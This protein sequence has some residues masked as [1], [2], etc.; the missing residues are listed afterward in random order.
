MQ[1]FVAY[2][3]MLPQICIQFVSINRILKLK[4]E[5]M[6]HPSLKSI[7]VSYADR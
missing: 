3:D 6:T 5:W 2:L 4:N 7:E 1:I